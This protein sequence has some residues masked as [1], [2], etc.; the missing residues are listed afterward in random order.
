MTYADYCNIL[1][2]FGTYPLIIR[3]KN[4]S[5]D[6]IIDGKEFLNL[7]SYI[8]SGFP[9]LASFQGHVVSIIGHT[10]DYTKT[11]SAAQSEFIDSSFFLNRFVVVDDNF[12]PYQLLGYPRDTQNYGL[13]YSRSYTINSI[14]TAVCPLPEKVFLPAEE[15]RYKAHEYFK[16]YEN[17]LKTTGKGPWITRLYLTTNSSFKR[18]KLEKIANNKL[19]DKM[20][21]FIS[22]I[23]MPHFI[24]VMEVSPL[25]SYKNCKCTAEIVLD[26]TSSKNEDSTIYMRIG[27]T[28]I[29][30]N[31]MN[32]IDNS[33]IEFPQYTHNL[34]ER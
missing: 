15:A 1:S 30:K 27:D 17:E 32:K 5:Q 31:L 4:N 29:F 26:P 21:F 19:I 10:I 34:G 13:K 11:I 24:W 12:F 8:E 22:Q 18:R 16:V 9:V 7:Y 25:Q 3:L 2:K 33:L 28:L 14:V 6:P 20:S 23:N